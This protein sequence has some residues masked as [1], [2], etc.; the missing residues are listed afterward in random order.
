MLRFGILTPLS[1]FYILICV[2]LDVEF[3]GAELI[4]YVF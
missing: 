3:S 4:D 1:F 2:D